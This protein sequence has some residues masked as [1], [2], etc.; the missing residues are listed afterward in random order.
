M[1]KTTAISKKLDASTNAKDCTNCAVGVSL[2]DDKTK[3]N[4]PHPKES[5]TKI[6]ATVEKSEND[7]AAFVRQ[8]SV[9]SY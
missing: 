5:C 6:S 8:D 1:L 2:V 7:N 3:S 9:V 4:V